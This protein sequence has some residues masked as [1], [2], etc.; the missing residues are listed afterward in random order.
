VKHNPIY[1]RGD[2]Y[3]VPEWLREEV[4]RRYESGE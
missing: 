3:Y 4:R 1:R 2:T